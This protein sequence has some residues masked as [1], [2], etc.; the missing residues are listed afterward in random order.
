MRKLCVSAPFNLPLTNNPPQLAGVSQ[1]TVPTDF[2]GPA[3]LSR[4]LESNPIGVAH[5]GS[6]CG[7]TLHLRVSLGNPS[8]FVVLPKIQNE[9]QRDRVHN[10][11]FQCNGIRQVPGTC[12]TGVLFHGSIFGF[13]PVFLVGCFLSR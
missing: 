2:G 13:P 6:L 11:V 4:L 10:Q 1:G 3:H 8:N 7:G 12:T 9:R 5:G